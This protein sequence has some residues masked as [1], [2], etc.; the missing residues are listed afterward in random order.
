[1]RTEL[2][3]KLLVWMLLPTKA[4]IK[5]GKKKRKKGGE[6]LSR[7]GSGGEEGERV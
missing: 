2:G 7:E 4:V 3:V 5:K 1:M 6:G